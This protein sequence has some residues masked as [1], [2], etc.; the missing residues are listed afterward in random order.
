MPPYIGR[1][2]V[3]TEP[4]VTAVPITPDDKDWTWV[5]AQPC[6]DCGFDASGCAEGDVAELVRDNARAWRA[7][8][9]GAELTRRPDDATWS[10]LEYACHVRD[11]YRLYDWRIEKMLTDD[12]PLYPNWDQDVTAVDDRY[13]EQ[14]PALVAADIEEAADAL[15]TRLDSIAGEQ[16]DRPGRRSDNKAFTIATIARYMVHDPIHHLWDVN[17]A[18]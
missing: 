18:R 7:V 13:N 6:A 3:P 2:T 17:G 12:D 5:L 16:W 8:L 9:A 1:R 14:D 4:T 15:A 11:V 10:P